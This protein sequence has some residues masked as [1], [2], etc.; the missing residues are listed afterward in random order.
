[1]KEKENCTFC[2]D[3]NHEGREKAFLDIDRMI[4]EGLAGGTV[5]SHKNATNI[6]ESRELAE[7]DP[8]FKIT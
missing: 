1:M 6:E 2:E 5:H 7:E 4:N 8:P 3:T